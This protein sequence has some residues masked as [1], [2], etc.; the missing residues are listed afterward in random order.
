MDKTN[1][2]TKRFIP[3]NICDNEKYIPT[4][5]L[6]IALFVLEIDGSLNFDLYVSSLRD[7][8]RKK[9]SVLAR[10]SNFISLNQRRTLMKTFIESQFGY[11][12]LVEMFHGKIVK[13]NPLA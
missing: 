11:R 1:I 2:Q 3:K 12:P 7:K 4:T 8:A 9:L 5:K 6:F 13:K 10:L